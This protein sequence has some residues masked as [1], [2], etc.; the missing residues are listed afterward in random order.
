MESSVLGFQNVWVCV[1]FEYKSIQVQPNWSSFLIDVHV[2]VQ[3]LIQV[4]Q[5]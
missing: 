1:K 5:L 3:G 2:R 4:P